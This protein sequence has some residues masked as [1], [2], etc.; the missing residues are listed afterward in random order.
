MVELDPLMSNWEIMSDPATEIFE[1]ELVKLGRG[2]AAD[3]CNKANGSE[4]RAQRSAIS[5]SIPITPVGLIKPDIP[6]CL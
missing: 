5:I 2:V 1:A 4:S 6:T 3:T